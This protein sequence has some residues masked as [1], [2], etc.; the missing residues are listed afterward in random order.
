M[1]T[2]F[3]QARTTDIFFFFSSFFFGLGTQQ[4]NQGTLWSTCLPNDEGGRRKRTP[5]SPPS[6]PPPNPPPSSW[7]PPKEH[8]SQHCCGTVGSFELSVQE[9]GARRWM[10][11]RM[12]PPFSQPC[13]NALQGLNNYS[14]PC[15]TWT[16]LTG[17]GT[18]GGKT[19]WIFRAKQASRQKKSRRLQ[20]KK[21]L[22]P[23]EQRSLCEAKHQL[24]VLV[25]HFSQLIVARCCRAYHRVSAAPRSGGLLTPLHDGGG[26]KKIYLPGPFLRRTGALGFH[27]CSQLP[28]VW[29]EAVGQGLRGLKLRRV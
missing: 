29:T 1:T 26:K 25:S 11:H 5:S 18:R 20:N 14:R 6:P 17:Q 4:K 21:V 19:E 28:F 9:E 16:K 10:A 13:G 15:S 2:G 24:C 12:K 27:S 23:R 22:L 3:I 8:Q 7:T